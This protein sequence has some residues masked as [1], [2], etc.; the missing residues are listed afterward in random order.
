MNVTRQKSSVLFLRFPTSCS[1]FTQPTP[2][3]LLRLTGRH[4]F[5]AQEDER[6]YPESEEDDDQSDNVEGEAG[7]SHV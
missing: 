5:P 4:E 1:Y 3:V 2:V 6:R 7:I